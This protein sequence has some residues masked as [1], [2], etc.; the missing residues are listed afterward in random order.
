METHTGALH[1]VELWRE[2]AEDSVR[3]EVQLSSF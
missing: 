1:R 2:E 3:H